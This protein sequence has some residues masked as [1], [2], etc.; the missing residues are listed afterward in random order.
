[1][2]EL[3][4]FSTLKGGVN[5]LREPP[6]I[7]AFQAPSIGGYRLNNAYLG[8]DIH[9]QSSNP[10]IHLHIDHDWDHDAAPRLLTLRVDPS[11]PGLP[12]TE[13]L[14]LI[15]SRRPI[16]VAMEEGV[17]FFRCGTVSDPWI[18]LVVPVGEPEWDRMSILKLRIPAGLSR[19]RFDALTPSLD[20]ASGR[21]LFINF[22]NRIAMIEIL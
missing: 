22:G 17:I 16:T 8:G 15:T 4:D 11:A 5:T 3:P 9:D 12:V 21:M 10:P 13:V 14:Q 2:Y 19:S 1:L 6:R 20:L 7:I 18:Y